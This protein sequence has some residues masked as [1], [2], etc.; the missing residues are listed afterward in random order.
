MNGGRKSS[1]ISHQY[2][3]KA[4]LNKSNSQLFH[5]FELEIAHQLVM[6]KMKAEGIKEGFLVL[7]NWKE[8]I[9]NAK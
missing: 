3:K 7:Q 2:P 5:V 8:T 4:D 6:L 1:R 9:L